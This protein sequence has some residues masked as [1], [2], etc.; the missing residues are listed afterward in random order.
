MIRADM[1]D[2]N[3]SR[4]QTRAAH[5]TMEP[6]GTT[7]KAWIRLRNHVVLH[8]AGSY[9]NG[10]GSIWIHRGLVPYPG[11]GYPAGYGTT[12]AN[13]LTVAST[14][15]LI[16]TGHREHFRWQSHPKFRL[17]YLV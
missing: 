13:T 12:G 17:E 1:Q 6:L 3:P 9:S 5:G 2:L 11:P 16:I 15:K 7:Q 4:P 10:S 8:P 14:K